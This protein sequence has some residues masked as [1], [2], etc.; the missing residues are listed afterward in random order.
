[1][2]RASVPRRPANG[3][4][5]RSLRGRLLKWCGMALLLGLGI[6]GACLLFR[7]AL[8][9][10]VPPAWIYAAAGWF[11]QDA[12]LQLEA[13]TRARAGCRSL[14]AL[15]YLSSAAQLA[16]DS[17]RILSQYTL[18]LAEAHQMDSVQAEL[19]RL[20]TLAPGSPETRLVEARSLMEAGNPLGSIGMLQPLLSSRP[21][22][23]EAWY[24]EGRAQDQLHDTRRAEESFTRAIRIDPRWA[25]FYRERAQVELQTGALAEAER[26]ARH[27]LE[28]APGDDIGALV[29]ASVLL[30]GDPSPE[31]IQEVV[32][33]LRRVPVTSSQ[34]GAVQRQLGRAYGM[35][36]RW[37]DAVP[38]LEAAVG[39]T[40]GDPGIWYALA[41]AYQRTGDPRAAATLARFRG[42]EGEQRQERYLRA[43]VKED[44]SGFPPR[45]RLVTFYLQHHRR[46]DAQQ[47]LAEYLRDHPRDPRARH[48]AAD[49]NLTLPPLPGGSG[50]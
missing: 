33:I 45:R 46:S 41:Q 9:P 8:L 43:A 4:L 28:L 35:L 2:I 3:E 25:M 27:A 19:Q 22:L 34:A 21:E 37:K 44:Q 15:T 10:R 7:D 18:A 17:P 40:P 50:S 36:D 14:D 48:L 42:L 49:L 12:P 38:A 6:L 1:M 23:A 11:P 5:A 29:L 24:V 20:R 16:P 30:D 13:G 31:R 39:L 47:V 32:G 26:D